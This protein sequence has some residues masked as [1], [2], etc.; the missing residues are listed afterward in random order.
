MLERKSTEIEPTPADTVSNWRKAKPVTP[1]EHE[2]SP[3]GL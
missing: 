3:T 1:S 2:A